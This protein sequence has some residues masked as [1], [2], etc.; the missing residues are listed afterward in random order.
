MGIDDGDN[1]NGQSAH[2][3][4]RPETMVPGYN[5][6]MLAISVVEWDHCPVLDPSPFCR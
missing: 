6:P 4:P 2:L 5:R 1:P 3:L